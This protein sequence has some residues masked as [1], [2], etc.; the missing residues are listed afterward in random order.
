MKCFSGKSLLSSLALLLALAPAAMAQSYEVHPYGGFYWP[1]TSSSGHL[2]D[3][4]L[5]GIKAGY[6]LDANVEL[7]A[8]LGYLNHF[9]VNDTNA[10]TRGLLWEFGG[11]Y[12]FSTAEFPFSH[13]FSPFLILT[14]GGIT[15]HAHTYTFTE[16]GAIALASGD[17]LATLRTIQVRNKNTFFDISYGLGIKSMKIWGP[18]GFRAEIR[19]RTIPN[20]YHGS[21]TILEAT[22]GLN[23][24]W[25]KAQE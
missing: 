4:G 11:S 14:A 7:E 3:G 8:N 10:R 24:I 22:T 25:G 1:S 9:Q 17:S 13:K 23:I 16:P 12:N 15:T 19:G 20:F 21:P 6:F 2:R 5:Y 18:V